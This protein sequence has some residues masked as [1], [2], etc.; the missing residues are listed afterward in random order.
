MFGT[1]GS[2]YLSVTWYD[3]TN[4]TDNERW[5]VTESEKNH[6][7]GSPLIY[8]SVALLLCPLIIFSFHDELGLVD[9]LS[10]LRFFNNLLNEAG[11]W[12]KCSSS[13]GFPNRDYL[14]WFENLALQL[15]EKENY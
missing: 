7:S 13:T 4:D 3:I 9:S 15:F 1:V 12:V 11:F 8:A 5:Q 10:T 14:F 6:V 2:L